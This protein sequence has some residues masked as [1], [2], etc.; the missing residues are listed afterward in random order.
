[1][2][3]KHADVIHA[4]AEGAEVEAFNPATGKWVST[5]LPVFYNCYEYRIKPKEP[6]WWENIPEHGVLVRSNQD[7]S[8][9]VIF[10][11]DIPLNVSAQDWTPLTNEEI[12]RFKR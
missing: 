11:A 3:H 6:E 8:V 9:T 5:D 7:Y 2:R 10:N 4:W 12:E 1:M